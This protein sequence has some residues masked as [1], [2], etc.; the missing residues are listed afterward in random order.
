[1][2]APSQPAT[3][4]QH[5]TRSRSLHGGERGGGVKS[6]KMGY[7]ASPFPTEE[8]LGNRS[9]LLQWRCFMARHLDLGVQMHKWDEWSL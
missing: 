9:Y 3:I 8:G 2:G 6:M 1:M 4:G 7:T 5:P